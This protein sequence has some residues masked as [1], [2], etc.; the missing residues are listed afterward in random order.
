MNERERRAWDEW[1]RHVRETTVKAM[2]DSAYVA[3]LAPPS[4]AEPDIKFA[5]E[6][7]PSILFDEP[8]IAIVPHDRTMPPKLRKV[9]DAVIELEHDIDT[10]AGRTEVAEKL[11]RAC[12]ALE[13]SDG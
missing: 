1:V 8:V 3:Q 4:D 13:A 2:A 9:A 12:A 10:E 5:V 11:Q 7:G 6:I